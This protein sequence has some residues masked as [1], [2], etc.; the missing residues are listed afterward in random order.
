MATIL[1][2]SKDF[3]NSGKD[4]YI[5]NKDYSIAEEVKNILNTKLKS[6]ILNLY[7]GSNLE[8]YLFAPIAPGTLAIVEKI[9]KETI[10]ANCVLVHNVKISVDI[11]EDALYIKLILITAKNQLETETRFYLKWDI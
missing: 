7:F 8:N 2:I 3:A 9:I 6:R 10:L 5:L 11:V 1:D 4:V